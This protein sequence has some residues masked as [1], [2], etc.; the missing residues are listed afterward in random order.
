MGNLRAAPE[1]WVKPDRWH[2]KLERVYQY[3]LQ[4]HPPAGLPGRQHVDPADLTDLLPE[5]YM[6]DVERNPMRFRYRLVGTD[7]AR[8]MG[9]DLT[10]RY[11]DEVHPGFAEISKAYVRAV[12]EQRPDYR[13]G[14]VLFAAAQRDYKRIERLLVPLA[15]NG[16]DV[17]MLL[18]VIVYI[19][20]E[21]F[22]PRVASPEELARPEC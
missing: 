5:L 15:R 14:H 6:I 2:P 3:W 11:L 21:P 9:H 12:T 20:A 17:D 19:R 8:N 22:G 1:P 7:F 18:G 4:I 10:G 13:N 16:V